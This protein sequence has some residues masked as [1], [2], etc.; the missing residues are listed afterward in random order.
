MKFELQQCASKE[1]AIVELLFTWEGYSGARRRTYHAQ[2]MDVGS[3]PRALLSNI[4]ARG[5][6]VNALCPGMI[7]TPM[8]DKMIGEGREKSE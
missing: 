2:S 5:I 3:S 6:R 1:R 8:S 7:Q 4:A